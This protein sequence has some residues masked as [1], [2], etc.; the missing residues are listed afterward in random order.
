VGVTLGFSM[1]IPMFDRNQ[2]AI[3]QARVRREQTGAQ[4]EAARIRAQAALFALYQQLVANRD[5]L[6]TLQSE[7]L[8]QAQAALDQTQTGYER[9]RFSYLELAVAQQELV[10]LRSAVIDTATDYY[11]LT[12]EIERLTSESL[13]AAT[14][15]QDLP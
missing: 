14:H 5:R 6:A 1:A 15:S 8:P 11:R 9:G 10:S 12:A 13:T 2:G 7:A 3:A 4:E